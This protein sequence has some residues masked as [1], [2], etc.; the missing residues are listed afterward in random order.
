MD[1]IYKYVGNVS[2]HWTGKSGDCSYIKLHNPQNPEIP[3]IVL[4]TEFEMYNYITYIENTD[5][6]EK[7]L[8][9]EFY[10]NDALG[11]MAVA[12][13]GSDHRPAKVVL[14]YTT[15]FRSKIIKPG[16]VQ[17]YGTEHCI[18]EKHPESMTFGEYNRLYHELFVMDVWDIFKDPVDY[19]ATA[20]DQKAELE[21]LR[22]RV[23]EL[24][25]RLHRITNIAKID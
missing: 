1:A 22:E 5:C 21:E 4:L 23:C 13:P 19:W 8:E 6:E 18:N 14:N 2:E 7:R 15:D 3:P 20:R 10:F 17:F 12:I 25:D 9:K 16:K 24:E 11:L